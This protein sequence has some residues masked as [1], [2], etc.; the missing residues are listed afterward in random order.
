MR[1][2]AGHEIESIFYCDRGRLSEFLRQF[3]VAQVKGDGTISGRI[4]VKISRDGFVF[5]DGFLF[6][7]P[8]VG[9]AITISGSD[10][11]PIGDPSVTGQVLGMAIAQEALRD[12]NYDWVAIQLNTVDDNLFFQM[13]MNGRPAG[14]LPFGFDMGKGLHK[15]EEGQGP[16]ADFKG[17]LFEFNIGFPLARILEY[18]RITQDVLHGKGR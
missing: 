5:S 16:G 6:S 9:G 3:K 11:V 12:F 14:L 2:V 1:V 10:F 8:G 18:N 15:A 4:P 17:I 7:S 13:K